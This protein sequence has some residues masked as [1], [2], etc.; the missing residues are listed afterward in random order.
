MAS[1]GQGEILSIHELQERNASPEE[2]DQKVAQ[3]KGGTVA[4]AHDMARMGRVQELRVGLHTTLFQLLLLKPSAAQLQIR[5]HRRFCHYPPSNMGRFLKLSDK[6]SQEAKAYTLP[7][8]HIT[9]QLARSAQWVR[10]LWS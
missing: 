1:K 4:D 6:Q 2:Q 9:R 10:S 7:G 3:T 8:M 5:Q